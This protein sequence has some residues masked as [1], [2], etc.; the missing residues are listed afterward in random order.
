MDSIRLEN[1]RGAM[2]A[3]AA[4]LTDQPCREITLIHHNDTDGITAGAILRKSLMRAGFLVENI[5]IE[6]VHPAFLPAIH[7]PERRLIL[8]ADLG[9]QV[10]DVISRHI[11]EGCRVII[12]D[13]H[14]PAAGEFPRLR[15]VNPEHFGID[16]DKECAAAAAACF[17]ALA[18]DAENEEM[19]ALAV[20]GAVG[21]HQMA[22]GRCS[23]LNALLLEMAVRRGELRPGGD[24]A[25]TPYLVPCFQGWN[26]R[27]ADRL[28]TAL[29]VNGYYRHGA[30][31][32]LDACLKGP[33]DRALAFSVELAVI[34]QE[35]FGREMARIHRTGLDRDGEIVWTDVEDR[36]YP[37]GLKAIGMFCEEIIRDGAVGG[38]HYVVGFQRFPG[39]N[40][41]LGGFSGRETKVSFR[42]TPGLKR[43][44]EKGEK[45]DLM[46]LVP[47]AVHQVGGFAEACH[48][49]AAASTI[50]EEQKMDLVRLLAYITA[51]RT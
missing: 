15:Q 25:E 43:S 49:F 14:L 18:L 12:L 9:G 37:L 41:Y 40:P 10:A 36:F 2:K 5:P 16:G 38:D 44:I 11:P 31:L 20:L 26:L 29:A 30:D 32:A 4:S 19:A 24:D 28:I 46:R 7:T 51:V 45:P 8:Y 34:Q 22:E 6:R 27:E 42:V 17:F 33:D 47:Q 35:R 23:G 1:F 3:A 48:R 21:D 50:P 39:E 13:H